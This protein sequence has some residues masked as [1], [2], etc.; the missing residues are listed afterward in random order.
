MMIPN[1]NGIELFREVRTFRL[2]VKFMLATG[3]SLSDVDE[4]VFQQMS[5]IE[6]RPCAL[7]QL[8]TAERDTLDD[9]LS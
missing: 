1:R 5:A 2:Q 8:V 7:M 6:R 4:D 9:Q 3:Y